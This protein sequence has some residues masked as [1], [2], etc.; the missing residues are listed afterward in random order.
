MR[1]TRH[2]TQSRATTTKSARFAARDPARQKNKPGMTGLLGRRIERAQ[3]A[4]SLV[5]PVRMRTTCSTGITKILPS[6][7]LPVRAALMMAST[8]CSTTSPFDNDFDLDLG[9]EIHNVLGATI[10]LGVALLPAKSLHF[11]NGQAGDAD[12][13][14]GFAHFVE[15]EGLDHG[16]DFF[17]GC[18]LLWKRVR[19]FSRNSHARQMARGTRFY[20]SR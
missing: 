11:G 15:F 18:G 17:H 7:I 4:D 16:F 5:S 3:I 14:Q 9:Q 10:Q 20:A 6:P 13:G 12:F 19:H 8:A 1:E 2:F